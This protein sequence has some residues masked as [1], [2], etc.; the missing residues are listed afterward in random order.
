MSISF[1]GL[2]I[3]WYVYFWLLECFMACDV[4]RRLSLG[5]A[6]VVWAE[7]LVLVS[8]GGGC[9]VYVLAVL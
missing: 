3:V 2:I 1:T 7:G 6:Y 9:G 5:V 4:G 8:A